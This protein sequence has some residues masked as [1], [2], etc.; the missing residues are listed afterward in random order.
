[1]YDHFKAKYVLFNAFGGQSPLF[2]KCIIFNT[3]M[4]K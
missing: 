1:M 2:L 3:S 4:A